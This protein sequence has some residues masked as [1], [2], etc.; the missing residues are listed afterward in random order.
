[1]G[2]TDMKFL[3]KTVY[4]FLFFILIII[5]MKEGSVILLPLVW[6]AFFAFALYPISNWLEEKRL[7]RA[8]AIVL[9]LIFITVTAVALLYFLTDQVVGLIKDIP[10]IRAIFETKVNTYLKEIEGAIGLGSE[11]PLEFSFLNQK[12]LESALFGAGRSLILV[13][14][15]PLFIFLMLYYRDFFVAFLKK[16]STTESPS[17]LNFI[18]DSG[19]VIQNY[20][21]GMLIVTII[22]SLMAGVVLY[23]LGVKYFIL[24][25]VFVAVMNLIPFV[26]VF[27]SSL[28]LIIYVLLTT[29]SLFYPLATMLLLWMIQLIENNLITPVVV[30]AR[31]KVNA[32]AV[33]LAILLG[34]YIWGI[35]GMILFIPMVGLLKII[36]EKIPSL[37]AYG[38]LLGDDYPVIEK[39]ENY[40][41]KI[42]R[43]VSSKSES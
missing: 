3:Q 16:R 22:V 7:P 11:I 1:M 19:K 21:F 17:I 10:E 42:L 6:G 24:F 13:G 39:K 15:I 4:S 28:L 18:K 14:I 38:Y 26:G 9:T 8:L 31:V 29:D 33:I 12:N 23:F 30:G 32:F 43:K 34:G 27:L 25:A 36:F 35:S 20:L 5:I 40:L 41:R 37:S 2:P